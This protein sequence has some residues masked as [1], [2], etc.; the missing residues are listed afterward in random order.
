MNHDITLGILFSFLVAFTVV[1]YFAKK[2][3]PE[4]G[5][6]TESYVI[7][8]RSMGTVVLLLSM[9][10]TYF[11]TWTLLGAF[12]TY[13]RSGVWFSSFAVWT[14]FHGIFVWLFGTRIWLAGK[15]FGFFTPGQMFQHYYSS[16]RL[17]IAVA[18]V[19]ILALV[20]VMLIQI[21]GGA[22]ALESLTDGMVPYVIG[23][24]VTSLMV[25]V[26]VLWA[27]FKGTAWTDSFMGLFFASILI[28]TAF[29]AADKAGGFA[30]FEKALAHSPEKMVTGGNPLK[31][32]ELWLGLGFGAWV[33][34]HMWQKYY[35]A[36]SA[37]VLGKVAA[38]TPFWN[39]WMMAIIPLV[40]GTAA[41]IPGV[42]PGVTAATSDTILPQF[43]SAHLPVL[44]A[45]VV[46]GILAAAISTINSQLLSSASIV[47]EDIVNS[48]RKSPMTSINTVR[49]TKLA[50]IALTLLVFVL[51]LTP[52]G[53]GFLIPIASLGFGL[54]LQIVPSALGIL[55][56]RS[57]SEAGA[58][59]GLIT[60]A[61]AMGISA[62]LGLNFIVGHG[63][64][65][66]IINV[67]VTVVISQ[68]TQPV[69]QDSVAQYHNMYA[70]YMTDN[71]STDDEVSD[72]IVPQ[73]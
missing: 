63:L 5:T 14:I 12:G 72:H 45:F 38:M 60:G 37:E 19:G 20:P 27:G 35:S 41:M 25:G 6:S 34:P 67:I 66:L 69:S 58:F 29:Y 18:I 50:V 9:G 24:T 3:A 57:I 17:R 39:S 11:S 71:V 73:K 10:A 48:L 64:F 62:L 42:V 30:L 56:F 59:W 68:K 7:G 23:V 53:A 70:A 43:F 21:S 22:Q 33:L 55:Y 54:G 15:K 31:M 4:T 1:A 65:G 49:V 52:G 8:G 13:Y 32:I 28:F 47:A 2:N 16:K 61:S 44:G 46:A 40:V 26:I 51:A 36:S